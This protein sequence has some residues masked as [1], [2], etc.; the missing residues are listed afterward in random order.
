M[1]TNIEWRALLGFAWKIAPNE[2]RNFCSF[3][4]YGSSYNTYQ[5]YHIYAE[6][7]CVANTWQL[8][9]DDELKIDTS[10]TDETGEYSFTHFFIGTTNHPDLPG[11]AVVYFDDIK[12]W[13][14]E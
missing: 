4:L 5:W 3:A 10:W 14:D 13:V 1:T 6:I 11:Y 12:F 8:W 7:D 2:S 9:V